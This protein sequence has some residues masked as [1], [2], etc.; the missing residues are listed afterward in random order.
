MGVPAPAGVGASGRPGPGDQANGVLSGTFQAIGVSQP[1]A[2]R[3]SMNLAL[4]ASY[5]TTLT[6]VNGSP[7]ATVGA[8]G[9]IAPGAAVNGSNVPAGT[10][11]GTIAGTAVTLLLPTLTLRAATNVSSALMTGLPSTAGLLGSTVVGTGIPASTTVI[12]IVTAAV[13]A[14]NDSPGVPGVVRLSALPT[15]PNSIHNSKSPFTF[16]LTSQAITT[17]ADAAAVFTGAAIVY[18]GTI[19]VERSFDGGYTWLVCNVGGQGLLA[20]YMAGTPIN[21][22]F[23]EWEKE[24][25]YRLNCT[26]YTSGLMNY[27]MSQ[28]GPAATSL[29]IGGQ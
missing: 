2:F 13:A 18:V 8:G 20:Q 28:T 9:T 1:F 27:R 6:T 3:G 7:A 22:S 21:N 4:W 29:G 23:P 25:L 10:T 19:Q 14:T 15:A 24:V 11:I 26:A 16:K 5:N 17:G 12:E